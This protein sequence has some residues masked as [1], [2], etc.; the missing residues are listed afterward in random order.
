MPKKAQDELYENM[1][2]MD[3]FGYYGKASLDESHAV[4]IPSLKHERSRRG[5]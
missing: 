3:E 4:S 5:Y 2:F 1:A